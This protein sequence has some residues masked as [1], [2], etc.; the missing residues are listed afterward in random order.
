[1]MRGERERSSNLRS[2][3]RSG[4]GDE[5]PVYLRLAVRGSDDVTGC[6]E[7]DLGAGCDI[8]VCSRGDEHRESLRESDVSV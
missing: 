7:G 1:M 4:D 6:Q 3:D 5:S 8:A 2:K